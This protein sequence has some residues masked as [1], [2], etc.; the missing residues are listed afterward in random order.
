MNT[1]EITFWNILGYL[2][3]PVVLTIGFFIVAAIAVGI[4]SATK[5][6]EQ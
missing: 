1:F 4:L 2:A 5:D 6:K 3:T